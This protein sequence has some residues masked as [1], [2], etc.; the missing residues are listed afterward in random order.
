MKRRRKKAGR[1][2]GKKG[3]TG[4]RGEREKMQS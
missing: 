1:R 3:T 4:K 2:I